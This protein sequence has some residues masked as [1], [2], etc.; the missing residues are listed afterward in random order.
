MPP[1]AFFR[2]LMFEDLAPLCVSTTRRPMSPLQLAI[3]EH[4]YR[5]RCGWRE[6]LESEIWRG[7][8]AA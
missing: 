5:R 6:S 3:L 1:R 7:Y 8:R 2:F 4:G